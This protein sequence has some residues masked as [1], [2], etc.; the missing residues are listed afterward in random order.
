MS[1]ER[2]YKYVTGVEGV[3]FTLG[4]GAGYATEL[5]S[6]GAMNNHRDRQGQIGDLQNQNT[7]ARQELAHT[8]VLDVQKFLR[9]EIQH[10]EAQITSLQ[11]ADSHYSSEPELAKSIGI[12][13]GTGLILA[14]LTAVARYKLRG[15]KM[16]KP[17]MGP[18][19]L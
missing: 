5:A 13:A 10:H 18:S 8:R 7:V 17:E 12:G 16:A 14:G 19:S 3:A 1:S 2:Q 11:Q 4:F 6:N 15:S 9:G